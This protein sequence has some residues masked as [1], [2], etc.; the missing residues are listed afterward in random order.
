MRGAAAQQQTQAPVPDWQQ[1][2]GGAMQFEVAS[3]RQNKGDNPRVDMNV[4]M[5]PGDV[6]APVGGLFRATDL[7]AMMYVMFAYK[8]TPSQAPSLIKQLPDWAQTDRFDI[9]AHADGKPTKDQMRLMMQAL[10]KER[11]GFAMHYEM[12]ETAVYALQVAK[13]GKLGPQLRPH[14]A[15]V[16]CPNQF[17]VNESGHAV[18]PPERQTGSGGFPTV[19]GGIIGVPTKTSGTYAL[20]ASNVTMK[21]IANSIAGFEQF[22]RPVLDQTGLTGNYDFWLEWAP[23]RNSSPAAAS[24]D[25]NEPLLVNEGPSLFEALK[26]QLG[27]KLESQ[28]SQ[29]EEIVVDHIDHPTP[30]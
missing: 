15:D 19:C 30:N 18:L 24:Q 12:R 27:L 2:A 4:P 28:K 17:P 22:G 7:P 25:A 13:P 20:G 5:G 1:K 10:L 8:V 9:E 3:V 6:Y 21:L 11:F 23:E 14:P 16:A 29:V 26:E